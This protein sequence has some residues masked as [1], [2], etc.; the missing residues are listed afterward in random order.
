MLGLTGATDRVLN[1]VQRNC[2]SILGEEIF[3]VITNQHLYIVVKHRS[4]PN[5]GETA[6]SWGQGANAWCQIR[7]N[8]CKKDG[9][10]RKFQA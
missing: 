6:I 7:V 2:G 4:H 5:L 9:A 8:L 1:L 10:E 3:H